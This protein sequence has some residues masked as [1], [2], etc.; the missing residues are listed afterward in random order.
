MNKPSRKWNE[1][2]K[3]ADK[4]KTVFTSLQLKSKQGANNEREKAF[5]L[6]LQKYRNLNLI[7]HSRFVILHF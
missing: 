6:N 2:T 7:K 1:G 4:R 5:L 3:A